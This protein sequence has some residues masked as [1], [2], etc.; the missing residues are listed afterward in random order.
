MTPAEAVAVLSK[1]TYLPGW[2]LSVYEVP[3]AAVLRV[4][5]HEPDSESPGTTID[6]TY[7]DA[8][9]APALARMDRDAL[10]R[11]AFSIF[12]KRAVHEVEEWLRFEGVPLFAPHP[13]RGPSVLGPGRTSER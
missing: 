1:L 5:R 11:W 10:L 9:E 12:E 2:R 7:T 6:V 3:K 13:G 4:G 8:I